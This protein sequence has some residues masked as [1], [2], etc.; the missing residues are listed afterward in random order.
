MGTAA[1]G[2]RNDTLNLSFDEARAEIGKAQTK[3]MWPFQ[4]PGTAAP[5][6]TLH[7][8][9]NAA[10]VQ[11]I[12]CSKS[13][14]ASDCR[15]LNDRSELVYGHNLVKDYL[16]KQPGPVAAALAHGCP[17]LDVRAVIY[18]ASF[19][20]HGDLLSQWRGYSRQLD[21]YSM[22]FRFAGLLACTNVFLSKVVYVP[23]EQ[24]EILRALVRDIADVFSRIDLPVDR[25]TELINIAVNTVWALPFRFKDASFQGE[26]EWRLTAAP[27]SGYHEKFRIADGHFVPYVQI[28]FDVERLIEVRQGPGTY[29]DANVGSLTRLLAAE[30]FKGTR[31]EKSPVPL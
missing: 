30:N 8:Y 10:G 29:R 24:E 14:W 9:T 23:G 6:D 2:R 16:A 31:V 5:P 11:G 22:A 12:L 13:L 21:G 27:E 1:I 7:H 15:F 20:E 28:P 18:I 26:Q 25:T 3:A 4:L 19:C 17:P